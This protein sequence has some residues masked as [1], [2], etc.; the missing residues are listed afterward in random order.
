MNLCWT[1]IKKK[2][3]CEFW[4]KLGTKFSLTQ[5]QL[6][7]RRTGNVKLYLFKSC[8][9]EVVDL[10]LDAANVKGERKFKEKDRFLLPLQSHHD[11]D[12]HRHR[13]STFPNQVKGWHGGWQWRWWHQTGRKIW[14]DTG[15]EIRFYSGS[16]TVFVPLLEL[17]PVVVSCPPP[18][19]PPL[20]Y[21]FTSLIL[22]AATTTAQSK[23]PS[24][25]A[26]CPTT[27]WLLRQTTLGKMPFFG[28]SSCQCWQ[29]SRRGQPKTKK[30]GWKWHGT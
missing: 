12:H 22:T 3:N 10:D 29:G 5:F 7:L 9:L 24:Y 11:R 1:D 13:K 8:I 18:S 27:I 6:Q 19:P 17:V 28:V 20:R 25:I 16:V 23:S 26:P 21:H 2:D 15:I 30:E 14:N 4:L